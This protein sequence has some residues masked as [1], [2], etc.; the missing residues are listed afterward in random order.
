ML[1][2]CLAGGGYL[3]SRF[4]LPQILLPVGL[5]FY[6]FQSTNYL[7]DL[8]KKKIE[9]ERNFI[10]V[11]LFISFFPTI[12]SGPILRASRF[13][14]QL[15][16][17]RSVSFARFQRAVFTF[18]WG[19]FI[20][21]M[22][23]DRIAVFTNQVYSDLENYSGLILAACA[24][25]YS[26]Q[27]YCDFSGYSYM[28]IAVADLFGFDIPENFHQPYFATTIA[29]F[30]RRWHISLTTWFTD[31]LYIPLGGNRKSRLR[32]YIN[33][34]IVFLISGLWHGAAWNF[35]VWGG[36]HAFFQIFGYLGSAEK[37]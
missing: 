23:A 14:P 16:E 13:L 34:G 27:I 8:A 15:S 19:A 6:V 32:R 18:L 36:L 3:A 20:K 29:D 33:I 31:Y 28:A 35:V 7:L 26:I 25:C 4:Q 17:M 21:M 22:I 37:V 12:T 9:P 24:A 5:S 1:P 2:H 11:A 10:N 30:W